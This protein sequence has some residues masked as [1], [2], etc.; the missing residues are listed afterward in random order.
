MRLPCIA[1]RAPGA[2]PSPPEPGGD[3]SARGAPQ[4]ETSLAEVKRQF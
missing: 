4:R 2:A 3:V 1:Q